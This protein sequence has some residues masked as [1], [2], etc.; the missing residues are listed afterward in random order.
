MSDVFISYSRKDKPFVQQLHGALSQQQRDIWIDWE[1]IPI[2]ADWWQAIERGIESA[3]IFLFILTPHSVL[4]TVCKQEIDHAVKCNKR[5]IPVVR[6]DQFDANLVHPA[7]SRHNWLFFRESDDFQQMFKTLT[8]TIETDWEH[9]QQHTRLLVKA[10][11][12]ERDRDDSFLLRGKDLETSEQW[13][14]EAENKNPKPTELQHQY[15]TK[16]RIVESANQRL[17]EIGLRTKR[18]IQV[19]TIVSLGTIVVAGLTLF[20][21]VQKAREEVGHLNQD[22]ARKELEIDVLRTQLARDTQTVSQE[23]KKLGFSDEKIKS[24]QKAEPAILAQEFQQAKQAD[25]CYQQTLKQL[26]K[27]I[28]PGTS[29]AK[30]IATETEGKSPSPSNSGAGIQPPIAP[31]P[32]SPTAKPVLKRLQKI[33]LQYTPIGVDAQHFKRVF[34]KLGFDQDIQPL[35]ETTQIPNTILYGSGVS[36]EDVKIVAFAFIRAGITIR[37][38]QPLSNG[39]SNNEANI[40]QVVTDNQFNHAEPLGPEKIFQQGLPLP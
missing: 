33:T 28:N 14:I 29:P 10:I 22:I 13:Y 2:A 15:I 34:T 38:I 18:I 12:W 16:S 19:S 39:T 32:T 1:D 21:T 25:D 24:L 20:F 17:A 5:L 3:N 37:S 8:L 26:E 36:T 4:S 11:E 40:I 9:V 27:Q 35:S 31:N 7:L 30:I 23:L 6:D